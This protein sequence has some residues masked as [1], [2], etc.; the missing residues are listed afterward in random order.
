M[1]DTA[2]R[3]LLLLP[4]AGLLGLLL[5]GPVRKIITTKPR[6]PV[7]DQGPCDA[8]QISLSA[9]NGERKVAALKVDCVQGSTQVLKTLIG[10]N[11]QLFPRKGD[12]IDVQA[13]RGTLADSNGITLKLTGGVT[14]KWHDTTLTG[15][16]L[17]FN[18]SQDI[19]HLTA[20][21]GIEGHR[22]PYR[23]LSPK[24]DFDLGTGIVN[25]PAGLTLEDPA[26]GKKLTA[27][28]GRYLQNTSRLE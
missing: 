3:R 7:K 23:L 5:Y 10:A 14:L 26:A 24:A 11:I 17:F 13:A 19:G 2:R 28:S 4:L 12:A 20:A 22:G 25:F 16:E 9:S 8:R 21:N 15:D 27:G 1:N 6:P 18:D